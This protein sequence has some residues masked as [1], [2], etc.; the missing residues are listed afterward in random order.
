MRAVAF[1]PVRDG[2]SKQAVLLK[3]GITH[4]H[5]AVRLTGLVGGLWGEMKEQQGVGG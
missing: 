3:R 1:L 2:E 4:A 5:S